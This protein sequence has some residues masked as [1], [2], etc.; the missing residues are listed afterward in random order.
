MRLKFVLI[1][2]AALAAGG[3]NDFLSSRDAVKNPSVPTEATKDQ[4]FVG[5]QAG[6]YLTQTGDI[7][8]TVAVWMQQMAG[9]SNQYKPL[10]VYSVNEG[11]YDPYFTGIYAG[12]G[13]KDIRD[14]EAKATADGDSLYLGIAK[15][16]EAFTIGTAADLWGNIPYSEAVAGVATPKLDNQLDVYARIQQVLDEAIAEIG[17]GAGSGPGSADLSYGGD[18]ALW[19]KLAHTLKARYYLHTAEVNGTAA[20]QAALAQV[21]DGLTDPSEDFTTYQSSLAPENNLWYQFMEIQRPGYM[22]AGKYLVDLLESRNDP[23][24]QLY[25]R[26][27]SN[28]QFAGA[29]PGQGGNGSTISNLGAERDRPDFRQ[30]MITASEN[31]L[32]WA[33]AA[34]KTGDEG[35]ARA[36]LNAERAFWGLSAVSLGGQALFTEIMT[37]KYIALFQQI[38]VWSDYRR[39]CLPAL[40]PAP[41]AAEIPRRLYY[42]VTE[43]STNPNIPSVQEQ[44]AT[45]YNPN[46]PNA[47][48]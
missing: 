25:F 17:S 12:G 3:C 31:L 32:I 27:A 7:A 1:T 36:Q 24:L 13:L 11:T 21:P 35:T 43:R 18:P 23:R 28:G 26:P 2:A 6:Q 19:T 39:T 47:C 34:Y 40:V 15:V 22:L 5:I 9:V 44:D 30:P 45:P 37:E 14:L 8:R 38:E 33:E 20:Y 46:D 10:G 42:G 29:A 4:L 16:W 48:R 41:G